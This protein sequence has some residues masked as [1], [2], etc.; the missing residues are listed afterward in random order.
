M[1][2]TKR[3]RVLF[4]VEYKTGLRKIRNYD[5]EVLDP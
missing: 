3:F 5:I 2:L 1:I 4:I